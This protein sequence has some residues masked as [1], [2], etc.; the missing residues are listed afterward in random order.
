[1]LPRGCSPREPSNRWR[2]QTT[3][4]C[5]LPARCAAYCSAGLRP[6]KRP[7]P[8]SP[9][10][11]EERTRDLRDLAQDRACDHQVL[12]PG[13]TRAL[14]HLRELVQGRAGRHDVVDDGDA[15]SGE[16]EI[17]GESAANVS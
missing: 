16:I 17:A 11:P 9:A 7:T 13:G 4:T 8:C 15:F 10:I 2:P 14:Q 12:D 6:A 5:R 1:M 3:W